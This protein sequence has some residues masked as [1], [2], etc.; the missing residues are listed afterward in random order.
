MLDTLVRKENNL[1]LNRDKKDGMNLFKSYFD[2]TPQLDELNQNDSYGDLHWG[3]K[4]ANEND[5]WL[6]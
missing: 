3:L 6:A 2:L 4:K 5:K 1:E